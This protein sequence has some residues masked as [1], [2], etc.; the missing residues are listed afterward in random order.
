[1]D[2]EL[3]SHSRINT[4]KMCP[5]QYEYKYIQQLT[6]LGGN[7]NNLFLGGL[8]H[9]GVEL[10]SISG[11]LNYIDELNTTPN[12]DTET[13]INLALTMTEAYFTKFGYNEIVHSEIPFMV[14]IEENIGFRGIIDGL[15]ED[16]NGYWLLE[17]KTA[18]VINKEYIDKLKFNDQIERYLYGLQNGELENFKL[19][20]PILGIKYRILKKPLIRQKQ[21][22]SIMEFR[23]RLV[24]KLQEDD[25]IVELEL[26]RTPEEIDD[27][28]KDLIQ[29][30]KSI[31]CTE[32]FTKTLSACTTYGRCPYMELCCKE[33]NAELLYIKKEERSDLDVTVE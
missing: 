25:Y 29:D 22:E 15:I 9:K 6:P 20:K 24:D 23:N 5:K 17:I 1:M 13:L 27:A 8:L 14:D 19:D 2:K 16:D 3:Y 31:K 10:K 30:I 12:E 4:F 11:L 18:S 26:N 28:M 21:N 33:E 7:N 32:R